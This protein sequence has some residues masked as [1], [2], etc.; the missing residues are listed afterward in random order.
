VLPV[1]FVPTSNIGVWWKLPYSHFVHSLRWKL[2]GASTLAAVLGRT[3]QATND[4]FLLAE[5]N[6]DPSEKPEEKVPVTYPTDP[7]G[8]TVYTLDKAFGADEAVLAA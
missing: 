2:M 4:D 1:A 3:R 7:Q 5:K 8:F 6:A